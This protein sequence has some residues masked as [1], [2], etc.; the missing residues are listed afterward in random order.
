[1]LVVLFILINLFGAGYAA[2]RGELVHCAIHAGLLLLTA[3]VIWRRSSR[4]VARY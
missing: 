1:V 3:F 2:I 4:D